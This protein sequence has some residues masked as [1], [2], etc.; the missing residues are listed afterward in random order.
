MQVRGVA[1][2]PFKGVASSKKFNGRGVAV[3]AAQQSRQETRYRGGFFPRND[4]PRLTNQEHDSPGARVDPKSG[5]D[6][7]GTV[8]KQVE[9]TIL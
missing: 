1:S 4:V 2:E 6:M 7:G 5:R 9:P 8:V 3:A